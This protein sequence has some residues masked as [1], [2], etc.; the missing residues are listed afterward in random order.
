MDE[1][2]KA[3]VPSITTLRQVRAGSVQCGW[4]VTSVRVETGPV[5]VSGEPRRESQRLLWPGP[6]LSQERLTA[7]AD[8]SGDNDHTSS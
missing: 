2:P 4:W 6:V 5:S 1:P 3:V 7:Q 8:E